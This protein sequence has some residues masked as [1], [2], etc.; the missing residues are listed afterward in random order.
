MMESVPDVVPIP[1]S[2]VEMLNTNVCRESASGQSE[3]TGSEEKGEKSKDEEFEEDQVQDESPIDPENVHDHGF[4]KMKPVP[5]SPSADEVR[6]HVA[7]HVPFRSWCPKCV[8]GRG[9]QSGH[10]AS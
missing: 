7:T 1:V 3:G 6:K 9:H 10:S 4:R 8:A 5:K 2:P